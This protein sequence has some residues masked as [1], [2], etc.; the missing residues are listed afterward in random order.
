MTTAHQPL[1][2]LNRVFNSFMNALVSLGIA[3][4]YMWQLVVKGRKSGKSFSNPVNLL[5][6]EGKTYLVAPR[7]STQWSRNAEAAGEIVLKRGS[8]SQRY[9]VRVVPPEARPL[10]LKLYLERYP[11]QVQRFFS[12]QAGAPVEAFAAVAGDH[13]TYELVSSS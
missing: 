13:P 6:H 10:L 11:G 9:R 3:P 12:V 8:R 1:S 5:E 4:G 7:G 2:P